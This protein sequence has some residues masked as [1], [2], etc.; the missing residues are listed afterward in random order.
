MQDLVIV[1]KLLNGG[2]EGNRQNSTTRVNLGTVIVTNRT[3][4]NSEISEFV[5]T[6]V[7]GDISKEIVSN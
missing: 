2:K 7:S 3:K 4:G 1:F 5:I 6:V